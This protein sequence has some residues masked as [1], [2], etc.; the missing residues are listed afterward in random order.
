MKEKHVVTSFLEYDNKI[1]ILRRSQAVGTYQ[2][3]WA[4]VSGYIEEGN[5]PFEQSLEEIREETG[6]SRPALELIKKGQVLEV[7][8]EDLGRKWIVHSYRFRVKDPTRI[9][10]DW[11]HREAK[12][13]LPEDLA[14]FSTVP[15]LKETW[16]RV[17]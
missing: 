11:E 12:W 2:G 10:I 3:K 4:G 9:R 15:K 7:V 6:L 14:R 1:L 17:S 5:T 16:E 13:I 8:D